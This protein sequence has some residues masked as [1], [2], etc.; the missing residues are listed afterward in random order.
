MSTYVKLAKP[1]KAELNTYSC[2]M[3]EQQAVS[4]I[5]LVLGVCLAAMATVATPDAT[6]SDALRNLGAGLA[7]GKVIGDA[8]NNNT[9][10]NNS[11]NNNSDT[12]PK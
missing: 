9:G 11:G 4:N 1:I 6:P 12:K 3:T 10:N 8:I 5:C 7:A 2:Y